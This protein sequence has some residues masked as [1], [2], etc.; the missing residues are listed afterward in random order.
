MHSENHNIRAQNPASPAR[1]GD[2]LYP[3][4]QRI[5]AYEG[6]WVA[7]VQRVAKRDRRALHSLYQRTH[8]IVYT[9]IARITGSADRA[10]AL[11]VSVFMD[12]WHLAP[13]FD[14]TSASVL[15]WVLDHARSRVIA[16]R[17]HQLHAAA[18]EPTPVLSPPQSLWSRIAHGLGAG[19]AFESGADQWNGEP[20]WNEVSPG[21]RCKLLSTNTQH[22]RL[23]MLV[24]LAPGVAYPAHI[25]AGVEEL[26]LLDGELWID[27][28]LLY[29]G[30]YY[31]AEPGSRDTRV[32]SATGCTCALMTS[33]LDVLTA[34]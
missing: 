31:R 30:D 18:S 28:R 21:I 10:E 33:M 13:A 16:H 1:L 3:G 24:T 27:D 19:E 2:I 5:P 14:A 26:H 32:W 22:D 12:L 15:G 4:I 17:A 23:S 11:T 9:L 7:I 25:H 8:G 29:A 6:D 20:K 34:A